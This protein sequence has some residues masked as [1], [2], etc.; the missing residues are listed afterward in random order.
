MASRVCAN[1]TVPAQM[2]TKQAKLSSERPGSRCGQ[3]RAQVP[4]VVGPRDESV[5]GEDSHVRTAEVK[6]KNSRLVRPVTKLCLL[7]EAT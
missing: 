4:P 2:A 5:P 7:E 3:H 6:T 1:I